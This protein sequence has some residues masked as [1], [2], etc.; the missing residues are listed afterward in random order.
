MLKSRYQDRISLEEL[1]EEINESCTSISNTDNIS[2]KHIT[3][4][5]DLKAFKH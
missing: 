2:K 5:A 4:S 3:N 1:L